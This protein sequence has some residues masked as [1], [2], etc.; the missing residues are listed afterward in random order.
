MPTATPPTTRTVQ[1]WRTLG[2]TPNARWVEWA[3]ERLSAG[4]DTPH[5]RIVAGLSEPFDYHETVALFDRA[6]AELG[7]PPLD[8]VRAPLESAVDLVRQIAGEAPIGPLLREL[9]LLSSDD[10]YDDRLYYFNL[11]HYAVD[12]LR[13]DTVQWYVPRAD[14]TTIEG[15]TRRYARWWL[16]H[17]Y[18]ATPQRVV[19]FGATGM[20][21]IEVLHLA[22]EDPRVS[23]VTTIGRRPTGVKH[24]KLTEVTHADMLALGPVESHLRQ[25][26]LIVHCLGVY[27]NAV[28]ADEFWT[29]TVGYFEALLATLERLGA[30]PR[31]SLMG[32]QGADPTERSP[33]RF[34]K[35]KGRVERR[36][37]ESGITHKWIFRPGYIK[38]GRVASRAPSTEW[39]SRPLYRLMPFIGIDAVDLARVMLDV[40][41]SGSKRTLWT[42]GEMRR[43]VQERRA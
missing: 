25:A 33:F 16:K 14:R 36:L 30:D 43:Y 28:P 41:L 4:D 23:S 31:F 24:P 37:M 12:D 34:A 21:G 20:T 5:L 27:Q 11:L 35:A 29:V 6:F 18:E 15:E 2:E 42:N 9:S 17:I 1:A 39:F 13:T 3:V 10:F 32:A 19:L 40:G 7:V 26:D 8:P 38:P 22:L